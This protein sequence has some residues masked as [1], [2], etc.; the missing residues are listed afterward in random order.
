MDGNGSLTNKTQFYAYGDEIYQESAAFDNPFGY[1][2]EY[3]DTETGN[4]Y[5][6]VRYYD[7]NTGRFTSED[8]IKDGTNWY[9]YCGNNPVMFVDPWGLALKVENFADN[10]AKN[11][12]DKKVQENQPIDADFMQDYLFQ[13]VGMITQDVL[14][15]KK[16][17]TV[18]I[19]ALAEDP[20]EFTLMIRDLIQSEE[21]VVIRHT[22]FSSATYAKNDTVAKRNDMSGYGKNYI[23]I[24]INPYIKESTQRFLMETVDGTLIEEPEIGIT[25][26]EHEL[27]HAWDFANNNGYSIPARRKET[28]SIYG[29][30]T[31][32]EEFDAT[33]IEY[34][35]GGLIPRGHSENAFRKKLGLNKRIRYK[36][37]VE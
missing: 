8:P 19:K 32:I 2:G 30:K 28:F 21:L 7:P 29:E 9:A 6:R 10:E 15:M 24:T 13:M 16:D 31:R 11:D 18:F 20:D 17:G 14:R 33:G 26:M 23:L 1:A 37:V 34:A 36:A 25:T 3:A 4:I 12:I 27:N 35:D 22:R 5:L